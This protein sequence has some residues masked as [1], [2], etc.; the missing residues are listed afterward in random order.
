MNTR[1]ID[2]RELLKRTSLQLAATIPMLH[3]SAQQLQASPA[4]PKKILFFTRSQT[5]EHSVIKSDGTAPS[6]AGRCMLEFAG[7]AGFEFVETKDG[8]IFDKPLDQFDAI[9][10]FTTGNLLEER[11]VDKTPPMSAQGKKNL[12]EAVAAGKGFIGF[13]CASD[14]FHTQGKP[15]E[16]QS[17]R[18]PYIEMVGGEFIRHGR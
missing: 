13:H 16:N 17:N 18:D 14:T 15:F 11:S 2:R 1:Q 5:F 10:M 9:A 7:P 12:L 3:W 8:G 6:H 4:A